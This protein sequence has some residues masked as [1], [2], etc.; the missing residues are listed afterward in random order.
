MT[1]K[2]PVENSH[3][4]IKLLYETLEKRG[5]S[6]SD[7]SKKSGINLSTVSNWKYKS[8]PT[9]LNLEAALNAV[10]YDLKVEERK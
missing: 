1:L 6:Y 10:G 7:L 5:M 3:P 4:I 2:R 9:L 8:N